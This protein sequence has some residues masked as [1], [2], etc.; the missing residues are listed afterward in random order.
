V[1]ETV[2]PFQKHDFSFFSSLILLCG[3]VDS[4]QPANAI[5]VPSQ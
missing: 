1:D 5:A 2:F 4:C 3:A